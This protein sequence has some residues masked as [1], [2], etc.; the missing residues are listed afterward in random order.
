M[1]ERVDLTSDHRSLE[2][3]HETRRYFDKFGRIITH[4][5]QVAENATSNKIA[6]DTE[7]PTVKDY[8]TALSATFTALSY[9]YLLA[10]RVSNLLPSI[11]NIDRQDSGFPIYQ[12][13]LQM[14]SDATQAERR[15]KSLPS[16]KQLKQDMVHHILTENTV[17][18]EQQFAASQL[19]YYNL[20]RSDRIFWAHNDPRAV[21]QGDMSENRRSYHIHWAVYDS[22]QNI[23]V[24]YLLDVED[25]G[26]HALLKDER[27]WPR[28]QAH[29]M[30][31]SSASM[32]LVTIARGFDQDFDDLHPKR[33]RRIF[34]GPMYSHAFTEQSGPLRDVLAQSSTVPEL[35][36]A[37]AW[38]AETLVASR[39]ERQSA[40]FFSTVERQIYQ[41]D[42]L[43]TLG[44]FETD[45]LTEQQRSLILPQRPYQILKER[46]PPGFDHIRKYVVS[47]SGR[48]L[49][50]R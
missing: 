32:K 40:G 46:N 37:L 36:W 42:P 12:E 44:G 6:L 4:L 41:L 19:H 39:S 20:L 23:P 10:G 47:P 22:Q 14:A 29:L 8:L 27:R 50:Y 45:G 34:V 2:D 38:T 33:L 9:K 18:I 49:S 15:L 1:S 5:T 25:T 24:I 16:M 21:W 48:V 3:A 17:P 43:G 13:L 7:L 26:R 31:Q 11:L 28:V 35:D 30:A